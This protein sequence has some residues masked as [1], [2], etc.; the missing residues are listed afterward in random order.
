M[1]EAAVGDVLS[2]Q[3]VVD[4]AVTTGA[5]DEPTEGATAAERT[6]VLVRRLVDHTVE[7]RQTLGATEARR[8][9]VHAAVGD[10]RGVDALVA[11]RRVALTGDEGLAALNGD[12]GHPADTVGVDRL[13]CRR[14]VGRPRLGGTGD[15]VQRRHAAAVDA[16]DPD[17]VATDE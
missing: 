11:A 12:V 15:G 3:V 13:T 7:D 9:P 8:Q 2:D 14:V 5:A 6:V 10:V 16:V 4:E 17:E 1:D